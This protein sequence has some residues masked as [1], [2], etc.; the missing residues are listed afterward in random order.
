[1]SLKQK[2]LIYILAISVVVIIVGGFII[3]PTVAKI[4]SLR[5]DINNIEGELESRYEKIQSLKLSIQE[6]PDIKSETDKFSAITIKPG[7][8]LNVIT[9]LE[10]IALENNIEQNTDLVFVDT[11]K[12]K[13]TNTTAKKDSVEKSLPQYYKFSFLNN[14][15]F[16]DHIKYLQTLE[17]LPYYMIIDK[18]NF[19]KR[20]NDEKQLNKITLRFDAIIYV[21]NK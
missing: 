8:E 17:K 5:N 13:P 19:E 20:N 2:L 16:S 12:D 15:Y 4:L 9:E 6:L 11:K 14:G 21:D 1:M 7:E 10:K 3:T 18:L